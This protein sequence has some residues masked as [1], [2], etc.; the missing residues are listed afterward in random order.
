LAFIVGCGF[1]FARGALVVGWRS[2]QHCR[3]VSR[4][5]SMLGRSLNVISL[6]GMA[7]AVGMLVDNAVVV[8]ENIYRRYDGVESRWTPRCGAR[9]KCGGPSFPRP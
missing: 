5:R 9:R 8:L 7:F 6:A 4:S 2:H 3:H 1:W